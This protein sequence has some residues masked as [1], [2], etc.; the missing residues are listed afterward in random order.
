MGLKIDWI[1]MKPLSQTK[2]QGRIFS[3]HSGFSFAM[4]RQVLILFL[5]AKCTA[6]TMAT[7]FRAY[8]NRGLRTY[9][10]STADPSSKYDSIP[11]SDE[12]VSQKKS[13]QLKRKNENQSLNDQ[14]LR[15]KSKTDWGAVGGERTG[16]RG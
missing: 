10:R 16:R 12:S 14:K 3:G 13:F 2:L 11:Q 1:N 8:G 4:S 6:P 5:V 7:I 15:E 9:I